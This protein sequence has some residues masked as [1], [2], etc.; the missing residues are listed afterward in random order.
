M[1]LISLSLIYM[2]KALRNLC[3]WW[4][5]LKVQVR[6]TVKQASSLGDG[7][8]GEYGSGAGMGRASQDTPSRVLPLG[9]RAQLCWELQGRGMSL[10][11]HQQRWGG[12]D[13]GTHPSA[14][15]SNGQH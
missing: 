12:G 10:C 4:N 2:A 11:C 13:Q 14:P 8:V 15:V 5:L 3:V 7:H 9:N 6:G 1:E